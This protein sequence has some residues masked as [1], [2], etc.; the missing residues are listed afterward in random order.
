MRCHV[1]ELFLQLGML[2]WGIDVEKGIGALG[3]IYLRETVLRI[4]LIY[5]APTRF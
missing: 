4:P 3:Q 1:A 2:I 5:L